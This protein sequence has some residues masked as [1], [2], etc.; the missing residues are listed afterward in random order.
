MDMTC[1]VEQVNRIPNTYVPNVCLPFFVST[2]NR[3][4]IASLGFKAEEDTHEYVWSCW[5]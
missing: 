1:E 5:L 4:F 2:E 3:F